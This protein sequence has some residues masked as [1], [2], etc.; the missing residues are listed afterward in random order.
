MFNPGSWVLQPVKCALSWAFVP[1]A[2]FLDS[3]SGG[4]KDNW[5]RSPFGHWL[6]AIGGFAAL[7]IPS[8]GCRGPG[9]PTGLLGSGFG[10]MG[11]ITAPTIYPFDA[12]SGVMATVAATSNLVL[13]AGISF[14]GGMRVVQQLGYAFGFKINIG[15]E[16]Q[17]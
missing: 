11:A 4:V 13:T 6:G 5:G 7:N 12:C 9:L 10:A 3:W 8:A 15:S 17:K 14:F 2:V 1:S 16:I